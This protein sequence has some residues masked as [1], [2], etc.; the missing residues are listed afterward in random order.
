MKIIKSTLYNRLLAQAEEARSLNM[1]NLSNN[2][3]S[4]IGS[5]HRSDDEPQSEYY[6]YNDMKSDINSILWKAAVVAM[7]YY[8]VMHIDAQRLNERITNISDSLLN[9]IEDEIDAHNLNSNSKK[10]PGVI[11]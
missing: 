2:V 9:E 8:D 3:L 4:A 7:S 6:A 5:I 11:E 1:D 10:I